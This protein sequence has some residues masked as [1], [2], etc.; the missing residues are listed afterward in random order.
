MVYTHG[1][2][3][4]T[5][6]QQLTWAQEATRLGAGEILLT[7]MNKDGEK[8]GFDL[9]LTKSVR[10][11]VNVPVIASGG[12]GNAQHFY[13]VFNEVDVDAALAACIFHYKETSVA[14]VKSVLRQK[15]VSVR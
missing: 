13:D 9:A 4:L 2:R 15:G 11:A 5:N 14:E 12:A 6:G 1:G 8:S 7:S 10:E 3:R